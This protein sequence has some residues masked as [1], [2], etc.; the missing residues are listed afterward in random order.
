MDPQSRL[1]AIVES[2]YDAIVGKDLNGVITDWNAAA[3]RMFGYTAKEMIGQPITKII[4]P[5]RLNEEDEILKHIK[6]GHRIEHFETLRQT[7]EKKL[8]DVS[9]TISPI[10]DSEGRIVGASK[11]ARDITLEITRQKEMEKM[12]RLYDVLSQVNQAIAQGRQRDELLSKICEVLVDR[13]GFQMAWIGINES[14][15]D[16]CI[17]VSVYGDQFNFISSTDTLTNYNQE[18][19]KLPIFPLQADR[20]YASNDLLN[21][22][23]VS[24]WR[25]RFMKAGYRAAAVFPL[26][27][28]GQMIGALNVYVDQ[29][30]FFNT[31][32]MSVLV[33]TASDVS[34]ALDAIL[35]EHERQHAERSARE[36][37]AFSNAILGSTP[38]ILCLFDQNG[39]I[40]RWNDNL[41][42]VSGYSTIEISRMR[43]HDLFECQGEELLT[44]I[45][46]NIGC[47]DSSVEIFLQT[48]NGQRT[49][50]LLTAK[51]FEY[52]GAP[53]SL[54]TGFDISK[55]KQAE[56]SLRELNNS[57]EGQVATRTRELRD[58]LDRAM[59]ADEVKSIFLATMS[60]ELRTPL[61]SIIGFTGILLQGFAGDLNLEQAKQLQMVQN[62]AH[63][64]LNLIN[65]VLDISKIEAGQLE[66]DLKAFDLRDLLIRTAS[67]MKPMADK[68]G[69][70]LSVNISPDI[71]SLESDQRRV[72]QILINLLNNAIKFT[73]DGFV[74][75][76][77]EVIDEHPLDADIV[78]AIRIQVTDTGIG[79]GPDEIDS[80]FQPFR[81]LDT[82]IARQHEGTG[83][84]LAICR[85]LTDMLHGSICIE[86][87]PGKGSTFA[88]TLPLTGSSGH[89]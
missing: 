71:R 13:G 77:A 57:L 38:G 17:P 34:L 73:Q 78:Q 24:L 88:V 60:H 72:E 47:N 75:L 41:E 1:A 74:E 16:V 66:I 2:S 83:L 3:E 82:G 86:S 51:G 21:D 80:L 50:Y 11:I 30:D 29:K 61:N 44:S 58:A 35:R 55:L 40:I 45:F 70:E 23:I 89:E 42:A 53:C 48:K 62:S 87:T 32:V 79:I 27:E 10:R 76:A 31:A 69:I 56:A 64:L 63:H 49:P 84:G 12:S 14:G 37:M 85:R 39:K 19:H 22:E 9:I 68:K 15:S 54:C 28:R 81:Q 4:P 18:S 26:K 65:D 36:E 59:A 6:N 52:R 8:I 25:D 33:E 5:D 20:P 46:S 7:K 43:P 67:A